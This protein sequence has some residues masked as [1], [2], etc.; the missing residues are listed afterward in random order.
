M[1]TT[2]DNR[3][4]R[5][6][7]FDKEKA[8]SCARIHLPVA[9]NCNV[10]CKF[11]D[12]RFDCVNES[13][14]GVCSAVLTPAAAADYLD[15]ALVKDPRITVVGIAGPGDPF[16]NSAETLETLRLVHER[17]PELALC[18]ASNG[19]NIRR[20]VDTLRNLGLTHAT[21]TMNAVD[22]MVVAEVYAWA[23]IGPKTYRGMTMG[24]HIVEEQT[25]AIKALKNAGVIVKV[26][27][28]LMPG[29]NMA[30]AVDVA[31]HA[32]SLG[33]DYMNCVPLKPVEGTPFAA[34]G[35]PPPAEV[36]GIRALAGEHVPQM[37][38]CSRCRADAS[39]LLS[40]SFSP[41]TAASLRDAAA[42]GPSRPHVAVA[43][44]EGVFVNLHLGEASS[45]QIMARDPDAEGVFRLVAE[46]D[47]PPPGCGDDRWNKLAATLADCRAL[48]VSM[49]GGRPKSVLAASGVR[50][51][52]LEGAIEDGL[53]VAYGDHP[54]GPG[55]RSRSAGACASC[56]TC[57]C[58]SG[59][60][61]GDTPKC[62]G[63]KVRLSC[64]EGRGMG[65]GA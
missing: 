21:I 58:G 44:M 47:A 23:R 15:R 41:E 35:E 17:H 22:P 61:G 3:A 28:I 20:H 29:I 19:L 54:P 7:C 50:V 6:P 39:G 53:A 48:L 10:Q 38:H 63:K 26:N 65:C 18:V 40:E 12:R 52:E 31:R 33:V 59:D 37:R 56:G 8:A 45:F 25:L 16:A 24:L 60:T 46:R 51:I 55:V 36:E 9:P 4:V 1:V 64:G 11:C 62:P 32:A 30:H 13:R 5:H 43:T 14:P 42:G 34:L 57:S 27:T 2:V 49:A